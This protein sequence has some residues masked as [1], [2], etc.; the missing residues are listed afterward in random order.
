M[1]DVEDERYEDEETIDF[2]NE[3]HEQNANNHESECQETSADDDRQLE[4]QQEP[5]DIDTV[6]DSDQKFD[7][8]MPSPHPAGETPESSD[9]NVVAEEKNSESKDGEYERFSSHTGVYSNLE[10]Y[11]RLIGAEAVCYGHFTLLD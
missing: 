1:A 11:N 7:A 6:G 5:A 4:G 3:S 10:R 2:A 8:D 9:Q